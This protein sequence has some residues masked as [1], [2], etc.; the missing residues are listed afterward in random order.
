MK[1]RPNQWFISHELCQRELDKGWVGTSG[2]RRA[3][4]LA[5][6]GLLDKDKE[7]N[8]VKYKYKP[9]K[10]EQVSYEIVER[11]G[12]RVAVEKKQEVYV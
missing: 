7:G 9:Q 8:E 1:S 5:D 3:Y 2:I 4:D 10:V 6:A 11:D 12:R